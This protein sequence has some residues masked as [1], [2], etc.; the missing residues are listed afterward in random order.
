M[1]L[2]VHPGGALGWIGQGNHKLHL[3]PSLNRNLSTHMFVLSSIILFIRHQLAKIDISKLSACGNNTSIIGFERRLS[4]TLKSLNQALSLNQK[5][6][7]MRRKET[8]WC[9]S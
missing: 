5:A 9:S 4:R 6:R 1:R 3:R 2:H 8:E 7:I